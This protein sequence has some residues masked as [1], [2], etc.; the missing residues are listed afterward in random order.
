MLALV[1]LALSNVAAQAAL[2]YNVGSAEVIYSASQRRSKGL[3]YWI[4]GNLGVVPIGNGQYHFY[5]ANGPTPVRT[6]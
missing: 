3:D 4:D 5:G 1:L 6:T 2:T